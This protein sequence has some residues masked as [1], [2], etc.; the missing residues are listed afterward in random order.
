MP[1]SQG[2]LKATGLASLEEAKIQTRSE[3]GRLLHRADR[4]ARPRH[5]STCSPRFCRS[6]SALSR[7]R[8]RC[9]GA[10]VRR[11]SGALSWV[12]PLHSIVATFGLETEE[13][14]VVKFAVDGIEA[15]QTTFGHRFMAPAAISVRR[16][17]DYEAKL[18][19]AKVVLDPER[20]AGHHPRRRQE[21]G[22]RAG[23]R[24]GRGP[25][26]AGRGRRPRRMAGRA[27]GLVRRELSVDPAGGDPRHHPQQ[28]EMLC[29]SAIPR[30]ASSPTSSS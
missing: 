14:D 22:L 27:D 6:S 3:E 18:A 4:K 23:L 9:A 17:E 13:P 5:A 7:G 30:R 20:R 29:A 1:R 19:E 15:G 11:K 24:T 28:P 12:R 25:G 8:N 26:A 21:P 2:F 16:F 10:S